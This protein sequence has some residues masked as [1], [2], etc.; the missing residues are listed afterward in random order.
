MSLNAQSKR[1][2]I[3]ALLLIPVLTVLLCSTSTYD[4]GDSI[5]HFLISKHAFQ[6]PYLF[7]DHW[8]KPLFTLLS[9]P[10]SQFGF[11][12]IAVFN[13][14][15]IYTS[16]VL[17]Y[18][19]TFTL[20]RKYSIS[21]LSAISCLFCT[22]VLLFVNSGLTEP[23]FGLFLIAAAYEVLRHNYAAA[24]IIISFTPFVRSEGM[25]IILVYTTFFMLHKQWYKIVLLFTGLFTYSIL[26]KLLFSYNILWFFTKNP[27][28]VVAEKYGSGDS[29]LHY[30]SQFFF[31]SGVPF[32]ILFI[33][34]LVSFIYLKRNA[35]NSII[36]S[37]SSILFWIVLAP[38][39]AYFFSHVLF[40]H[41]GCCGAFGIQRVLMSI[42]PLSS[43]IIS[44]GFIMLSHTIKH[45]TT[46]RIVNAVLLIVVIVFPFLNTP[47]SW[48][49][50]KDFELN[51]TQKTA[52]TLIEEKS[53]YIQNSTRKIL[54]SEPYI[55]LL[56]NLDI[57][58]SNRADRLNKENIN[59]TDLV[60]WDS[61]HSNIEENISAE[62]FRLFF[63][64]NNVIIVD[65]YDVNDKRKIAYITNF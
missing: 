48:N 37:Q 29:I 13:G 16:A 20:Y 64:K 30:F 33:L 22:Q 27:Y 39:G 36:A 40:W 51:S 31:F 56:L 28:P 17:V 44:F 18:E 60:I 34:G 8:G 3:W 4:N 50:N 15:V 38:T 9:S 25:I 11:K 46:I 21:I 62:D 24:A 7:F 58:D 10:F 19:T 45:R 43:V 63:K 61:W 2:F 54:Y 5:M 32:S 57:Y 52:V 55:A 12:G 47:S 23:L 65:H 14:I 42:I 53:Q 49:L 1:Y 59:S 26:G 35:I 6:H 41:I